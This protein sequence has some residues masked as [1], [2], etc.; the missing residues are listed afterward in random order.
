MMCPLKP[1][2]MVQIKSKRIIGLYY[3][4]VVLVVVRS[5]WVHGVYWREREGEREIQREHRE[6][7]T[8]RDWRKWGIATRASDG[9]CRCVCMHVCVCSWDSHRSVSRVTFMSQVKVVL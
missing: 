1:F 6:T 3:S 9:I 4:V 2:T 7:G 5:D 8:E